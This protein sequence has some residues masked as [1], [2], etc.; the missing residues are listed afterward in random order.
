M[1]Q[2][3]LDTP[4]PEQAAMSQDRL[5][6]KKFARRVAETIVGFDLIE[7][8]VVSIE[9]RWGA[10]KTSFMN[11]VIEVLA[12]DSSDH[13]P[14][15][16][17]FNPWMVSDAHSLVNAM[18]NQ[19]A[20]AL[21]LTDQAGAAAKAARELTSYSNVFSILKFVPGAEPFAS[22]IQSVVQSAGGAVE[23]IAELKKQDVI[24]QRHAVEAA[25]KEYPKRII[26]VIDDIDR[27]APKDVYEIVRAIKA[28]ADFPRITYAL[29]LDPHYV[30]RAIANVISDAAQ[31]YL[32]KIIHLRISLPIALWDDLAE[33]FYE[34]LKLLPEEATKEHF[35]SIG[36]R[37]TE[38]L[39]SGLAD[40]LESPR[41]IKRVFAR[42]RLL[43]PQVR[44]EVHLAD[45]IA[46]CAIA[47]RAPKVFAE[48]QE[49]PASFLGQIDDFH[50][51]AGKKENDEAVRRI[52]TDRR[53]ATV[54]K[55]EPRFRRA[56]F[57]LLNHLF[58]QSNPRRILFTT[59]QSY[60]RRGYVSALSRLT[61][62]LSAGL[63]SKEVARDEVI[64]FIT[65]PERRNSILRSIVEY[66]RIQ[67]F[68]MNL[69]VELGA[70][71]D[72]PKLNEFCRSLAELA[73]HEDIKAMERA[74]TDS[75][76]YGPVNAIQGAIAHAVGGASES[77][78]ME[79]ALYLISQT[80]ALTIAAW[81]VMA[82]VVES[83]NGVN[84]ENP[85]TAIRNEE[86]VNSLKEKWI[87][88]F[89]GLGAGRICDA[90]WPSRILKVT[91]HF[92]PAEVKK[93]FAV[94]Y[95]LDGY[96]D[97]FAIDFAANA[98]DSI[99]WICEASDDRLSHLGDVANI[100]EHAKQ[101]L[102]RE[103]LPQVLKSSLMAIAT[104]KK[105][106]QETGKEY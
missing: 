32:D 35:E 66:K 8:L 43:E 74:D 71:I 98:R 37:L 17:K 85:F 46:L 99:G 25:L 52:L 94:I 19:L 93:V 26:V 106:R 83:E 64:K 9:G 11:M 36:Q 59:E 15:V 63:P 44:A 102:S 53:E 105:Y 21:E 45:L 2:T 3:V 30:E 82:V 31:G 69:S 33:L 87:G 60:A 57:A 16:I 88:R 77:E 29:L 13:A 91:S 48:I 62:A 61:V 20:S 12:E 4:I 104:G 95:K 41:D 72:V 101:Q 42:V 65:F 96:F 1:D 18:L 67:R 22:I 84:L 56:L 34:Q 10:G 40:L 79:M 27:L 92:A 75:F 23:K 73:D 49:D 58:P 78:L 24:K 39:H 90:I 100:R 89:V 14:L 51:L 76:P 55:V 38:S 7:P 70:G 6:R 103:N 97:S 81:I 86:F 5:G 47:I 28:V 68:L 54:A 80:N 50:L